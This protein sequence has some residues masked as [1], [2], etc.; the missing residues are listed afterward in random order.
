MFTVIN[1]EEELKQVKEYWSPRII[2]KVN[3]QYIKVAKLKGSFTWH[4]HEEE[5]ELF[6]VVKGS[7]I[8]E[9]ENAKVK[10]NEG[11]FYVVPKGMK[12]NPIAEDECRIVLI[13]T[14]TTKHTGDVSTP[15][16]RSVG[17][18]LGK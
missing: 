17:Q 16:T 18:Q 14:I 1:I 7:M 15:E 11:D 13:E 8:I 4:S 5:D 12:H 6:Y 9:F 2:G 3:N 10:L